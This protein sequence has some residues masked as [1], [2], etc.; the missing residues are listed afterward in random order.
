MLRRTKI[1]I[2]AVALALTASAVVVAN[3]SAA[4]S[5]SQTIAGLGAR[6]Q[7]VLQ[8]GGDTL[9]LAIAMLETDDMSTN[10]V[11]GDGKTED[12]ANFGIFKQNWG[13]IRACAPEFGG[14]GAAD[15]NDGA[16]LNND[17]TQDVAA[18]NACQNL[19]GLDRWFGGHRNGSTGLANPNTADINS[20]K[21]AVLDIKAR[22][23]SDPKFLQDDT[24]FFVF[25]PAI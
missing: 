16:V 4:E 2:A 23:D 18:L 7:A 3:A 10:Y 8:A 5:G 13:M 21:S 22:L 25:V 17:L 15:F 9:D 20:Y 14:K 12:S 24:R 19:F 6:K 11:F 1:A